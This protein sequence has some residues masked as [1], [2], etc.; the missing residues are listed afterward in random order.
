VKHGMRWLGSAVAL[1]IALMAGAPAGFA[2]SIGGPGNINCPGNDCFGTLYTLEYVTTPDSTTPTTQTFDIILI[3]DTS[4]TT[5]VGPNLAALSFKVANSDTGVLESAPASGWIEMGGGL[6]ANGCDGHGA[7]FV[8]DENLI[9]PLKVP[10][11]G[12]YT[13]VDDV[14]VPTGTLSTG[15]DGASIK[16]LYENASG[17]HNGITSEDITLQPLTSPV[18]EPATVLFFGTGLAA[19]GTKLCRRKP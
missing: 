2:D 15:A 9:T 13:W 18:P 19:L 6:D 4:S 8:C 11:V 10:H 14:T 17:K 7:G 16:A 12:T 1:A 3:L 5:G